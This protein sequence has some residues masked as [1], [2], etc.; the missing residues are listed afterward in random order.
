[1]DRDE[2]R[3]TAEAAKPDGAFGARTFDGMS[4]LRQF[5]YVALPDV[6][7][8]L[9]D[10]LDAAERAASPSDDHEADF[11]ADARGEGYFGARSVSRPRSDAEIEAAARAVWD[12][13]EDRLEDDIRLDLNDIGDSA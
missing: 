9:L 11:D 7:L 5:H 4:R 3:A 13:L 12:V 1:M 8:A 2:L 6:V 10:A